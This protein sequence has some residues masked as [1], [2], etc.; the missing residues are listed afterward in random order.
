MSHASVA[1]TATA[2]APAAI[3]TATITARTTGAVAGVAGA[4]VEV[5]AP[6]RRRQS[7][8][9]GH[10]GDGDGAPICIQDEAC[11][12]NGQKRTGPD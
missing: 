11:R 10:A 7:P 4:P 2:I 6:H 12:Q 8:T 9:R 3:P 5:A 1:T